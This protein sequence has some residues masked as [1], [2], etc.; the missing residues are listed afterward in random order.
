MPLLVPLAAAWIVGLLVG[1]AWTPVGLRGSPMAAAAMA[2]GAACA[3]ASV[4]P[5][6][7]PP[8]GHPWISWALLPAVLWAGGVTGAAHR[9]RRAHCVREMVAQA[10]AGVPLAVLLDA[11]PIPSRAVPGM[12]TIVPERGSAGARHAAPCAVAVQLLLPPRQSVPAVAGTTVLA[13]ATARQ[14][15]DRVR[16]QAH[17]TVAVAARPPDRLRQWRGAVGRLLDRQFGA[18]APMARAL[19]VADQRGI[20]A[21]V[22]DRF[23]DAGLVHLLSV[24]GTHVAVI[25]GALATMGAALRLGPTVVTGGTL[26]LVA[27]YVLLLGAPPPAVRSAAMLA[28]DALTRRLQRPVHPWT[29]LGLGAV[30]PTVDPGVVTDLGWQLSVAGM[31]ALVVARGMLRLRPVALRRRARPGW[32]AQGQ[33]RMARLRGTARLVVLEGATGVLAGV[34]TAPLVAWHFGRLSL[35]APL[36]NLVAAPVVAVLQPALFLAVLVAPVPALASWVSGACGVLLGLFDNLARVAAAVPGAALPV[37]PSG[38]ETLAVGA[39]IACAMV[40][41]AALRPSP[42]WRAAAGALVVA[43][44]APLLP[45]GSGHLEAH[46][47]DVGQGD[48]IALRTPRGRWV[49]I[50]A[51]RR[52]EGGDAGRRTVIPYLRRRG[53]DVALFILTH[54][55]EDH[56]GGAATVVDALHPRAWWEPAF[57]TSSP[58][59]AQALEALDRRGIPWTR[60]TPGRRLRLDGVTFTV[61]APDSAWTAQQQD[62]NE[63]SVVVRVD[64]GDRRLLFTGDAE[65]AEEAWLV[66]RAGCVSLRADVLKLGHHGSR[67]STTTQFLEAVSPRVAVAS[68]G[69]DNRYGHPSPQVVDRLAASD[70]PLWRTDLDGTVVIRTDGRALSVEATDGRWHWRPGAGDGLERDG[71]C[72]G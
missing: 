58:A 24:S 10:D 55:H 32:W 23:A 21:T 36:A 42:W 31:A 2:V 7:R 22:R 34:V 60:A 59:Y 35:V 16:V 28:V 37:A 15:G 30:V 27:G 18:H 20:P 19:L 53:G 11:D 56:V 67:T 62:A 25:A 65:A 26:V 66:A 3:A 43:V 50:D 5:G 13:R 49:L 57:A 47:L 71:P 17:G 1:G 63:T 4:V 40:A 33:R 46:I 41:S 39:A 72:P 44:A 52:W 64:Y 70:I 29:A 12:V 8:R 6:A 69:A 38:V 45:V 54:A 9:L 61:L 14:E 48:A 68:V 51:G